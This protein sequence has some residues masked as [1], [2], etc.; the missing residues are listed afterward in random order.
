M[1]RLLARDVKAPVYLLLDHVDDCG[2]LVLSVNELLESVEQGVREM[3][4]QHVRADDDLQEVCA[5]LPRGAVLLVPT[6]NT[7]THAVIHKHL[8]LYNLYIPTDGCVCIV[9][10]KNWIQSS[11]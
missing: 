10:S 5:R 7:E 2:G 11:N 3:V 8:Y 4:G 1:L 6:H 9:F